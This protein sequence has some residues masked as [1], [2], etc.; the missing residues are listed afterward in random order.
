M[1]LNDEERDLMIKLYLAKSN[2]TFDDA[3]SCIESGRW[4]AAANR[5]YYALF[6]SI[7]ALFVSDGISV[8]SH[9]GT[10]A[11][12]GEYYVLQGLA[13]TEDAKLFS[14]MET[15][16]ERADYD[17]LFK[18]DESMVKEKYLLVS[19]MLKNLKTFIDRKRI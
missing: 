19:K 5:L 18:A 12:F 14:Q 13:S 9:R 2:E 8:G 15:L 16:R 7:A 10:R 11:K 6:H 1:S 17:A 3:R 4:N